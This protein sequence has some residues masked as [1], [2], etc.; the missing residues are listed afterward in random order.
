M[1][2]LSYV[3]GAPTTDIDIVNRGQARAVLNSGAI[4]RTTIQSQINDYAATRASKA[5]VDTQDALYALPSYVAAQDALNLPVSVVGQPDGVA[6][7]D[8]GTG[9]VPLSQMPAMG[10]GYLLGPYGPTEIFGVTAGG[11]PTRLANYNIGATGQEFYPM[12]FGHVLA[13]SANLGR[14]VIE[15]RI[16]S[17]SDTYANST[18]IAHGMGRTPYGEI[19][20]VTLVPTQHLDPVSPSYN[21]WISLWA[22]DLSQSTVVS[23]DSAIAV[24]V[25]LL[26]TA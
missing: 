22:Y 16:S 25:Y 21:T 17:G 19:Q 7:L 26:K 6:F 14:T 8:A 12:V 3:G 1:A 20:P 10:G 9:T 23:S 18:L 4:N 11:S 13:R 5:Y 2:R 24:G 15:A